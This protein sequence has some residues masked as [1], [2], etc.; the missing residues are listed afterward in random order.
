MMNEGV[1][2]T[3]NYR[4]GKGHSPHGEQ[5]TSRNTTTDAPYEEGF[6]VADSEHLFAVVSR[7]A[8]A[9]LTTAV[10]R[11]VSGDAPCGKAPNHLSN[12]RSL[13]EHDTLALSFLDTPARGIA[14]AR[15]VY[16]LRA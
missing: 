1:R 8:L 6:R 13:W 2:K 9:F 3:A 16:L 14:H 10:Q 5:A 11:F 15:R 12:V 7:C 4:T